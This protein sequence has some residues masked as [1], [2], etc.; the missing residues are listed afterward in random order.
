[1]QCVSVCW[2]LMCLCCL[3]FKIAAD[4][5]A[6]KRVLPRLAMTEPRAKR[7][8]R[9]DTVYFWDI[10]DAQTKKVRVERYS[11]KAPDTIVLQNGLYVKSDAVFDERSQADNFGKLASGSGAMKKEEK[12]PEVSGGSGAYD[13]AQETTEQAEAESVKREKTELGEGGKPRGKRRRIWPLA[14]RGGQ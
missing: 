4:I 12:V 7:R 13:G 5:L 8:E 6:L 11:T 14:A 1:M 3:T 2:V 9:N 10:Q